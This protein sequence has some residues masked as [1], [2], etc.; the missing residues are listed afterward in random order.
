[1]NKILIAGLV[2][3]GGSAALETLIIKAAYKRGKE[4]AVKEV[5]N[6]VNNEF[7]NLKVEIFETIS[8]ESQPIIEVEDWYEGNKS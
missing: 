6:E 4:V 2:L 7:M 3:L 8:R 5:W 1:M